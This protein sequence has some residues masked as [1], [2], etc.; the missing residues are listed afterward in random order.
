MRA[1][2]G[3]AALGRRVARPCHVHENGAA[4]TFRARTI[5]VVQHDHYVV[6]LVLAPKPLGA[7]RIGKAHGAIV[8]AVGR[9]IAPAVA[10]A[11]RPYRQRCPRSPY[12][13]RPIENPLHAPLPDRRR[14]VALTLAGPTSAPPESAGELQAGKSE[15]SPHG[16]QR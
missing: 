8:V 16:A 6:K 4:E 2:Q 9:G 11:D 13:V 12:P 7:G 3:D 14:A 5:V 10:G 1:G 15:G